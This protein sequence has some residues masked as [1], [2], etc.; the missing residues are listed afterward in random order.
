[1]RNS[2]WWGSR[3]RLRYSLRFMLLV[4]A[5]VGFGLVQWSPMLKR[6][7]TFRHET[8]PVL[9]AALPEFTA[10]LQDMRRERGFAEV[11]DAELPS[12]F[13]ENRKGF[14]TP[15]RALLN[16]QG[17]LRDGSPFV[18]SVCDLGRFSPTS[19][20][21]LVVV[22]LVWA[23]APLESWWYGLRHKSPYTKE[24]IDRALKI[25]EPYAP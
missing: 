11:S 24:E 4:M 18:L 22:E 15:H 13:A 6:R 1:M 21:T 8:A 9:Q 16:Y 14:H 25:A 7:W 20:E 12:A 10:A 3:F 19:T 2:M 23:E 5:L 17:A